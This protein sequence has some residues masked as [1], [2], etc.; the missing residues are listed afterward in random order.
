[1]YILSERTLQLNEKIK[2]NKNDYKCVQDYVFIND[3]NSND[4]YKLEKFVNK[5]FIQ[6]YGLDTE[7]DMIRDDRFLK[8][9]DPNKWMPLAYDFFMWLNHTG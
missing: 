8:T 1:M 9:L 2:F 4:G 5:I 7:K 6:D 3:I